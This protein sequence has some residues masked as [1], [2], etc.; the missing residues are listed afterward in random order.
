MS[1]PLYL[2]IRNELEAR[3]RSGELPP[4]ARLPTE[5]E[6]QEAHGIGRAT[7]QRV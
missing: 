7:A 5:A 6:L 1:A 4:G 2:R 3:I